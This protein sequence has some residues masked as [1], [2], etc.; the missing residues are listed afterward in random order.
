[1][2]CNEEKFYSL[3]SFGCLSNGISAQAA[4]SFWLLRVLAAFTTCIALY[5]AIYQRM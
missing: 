2:F 3:K 4:C 5:A 1:M